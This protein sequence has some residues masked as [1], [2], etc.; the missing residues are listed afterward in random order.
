ME[1]RFIKLGNGSNG[2]TMLGGSGSSGVKLH[3]SNGTNGDSLNDVSVHEVARG[4]FLASAV[5]RNPLKGF[6]VFVLLTAL[7][8]W[9]S[10]KLYH[11][12]DGIVFIPAG[13]TDM[14]KG[15]AHTLEHLHD[16]MVIWCDSCD[17]EA[18]T[19]FAAMSASVEERLNRLQAEEPACS[20]LLW[21]GLG[22]PNYNVGKGFY[23]SGDKTTTFIEYHSTSMR[24]MRDTRTELKKLTVS[25]GSL[26]MALGGPETVA[27]ACMSAEFRTASSH[28]MKA[29]PV[30]SLILW[31]VTGN[32]FQAASPMPC[33]LASYLAGKAAVGI[34]KSLF[35]ALN[36]NYDDS[37]IVFI[38]LA[39][40]V[41][42]AMFMW[43]RFS[44]M[45][46]KHPAQKDY[47]AALVAAVHKSGQ[48]ILISNLFVTIAYSCTMLFPY[49]NIWGYLALYLQAAFAC[50]FAMIYSLILLPSLA[51]FFP[52]LF[53]GY[54]R[55]SARWHRTLWGHL[56]SPH[57][58]WRKWAKTVTR[59]PLM[60]FILARQPE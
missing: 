56:P 37:C 59:R 25:S 38:T 57:D 42:Y 15:F 26:R 17:L 53:D 46:T 40:C 32:I 51:A 27:D 50:G 60:F 3:Y 31:L 22:K 39:L 9:W 55:L 54:D 28:A 23:L 12:K 24:C 34:F 58:M 29:V 14:F 52:T 7:S 4:A 47:A 2:D 10:F 33:V 18:E 21:S 19:G 20:N 44:D 16:A 6:A 1:S 41:D 35:P 8:S 36:V 43:T 45:R 49:M 48:V 13:D 11:M 5:V 30:C